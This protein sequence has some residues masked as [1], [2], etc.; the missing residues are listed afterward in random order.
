MRTKTTKRAVK[1]ATRTKTPAANR[2][3]ALGQTAAAIKTA[4]PAPPP[5]PAALTPGQQAAATKRRL[6]LDF[7][8]IARKAVATRA[9]NSARS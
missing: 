4:P 9:R 1:P 7:S 8:A 3:Q 5:A 2:A 6:G